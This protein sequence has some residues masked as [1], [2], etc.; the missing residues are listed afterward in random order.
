MGRRPRLPRVRA[1]QPAGYPVAGSPGTP[2]AP[3]RCDLHEILLE[4]LAVHQHSLPAERQAGCRSRDG[5]NSIGRPLVWTGPPCAGCSVAGRTPGAVTP[6]A[7][8]PD[9]EPPHARTR[10]RWVPPVPRPPAHASTGF[11]SISQRSCSRSSSA[12]P[13][14]FR[15]GACRLARSPNRSLNSS[16]PMNRQLVPAVCSPRIHIVRSKSPHFRAHGVRPIAPHPRSL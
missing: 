4:L 8:G 10:G 16:I 7:P 5:R 2:T 15:S 3:P 1:E 6:S 9:P 12:E 14:S 11:V 13:T